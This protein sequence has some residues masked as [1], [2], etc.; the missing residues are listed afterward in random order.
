MRILGIDDNKDINE[1]LKT[2]LIPAG[3]E[4]Q[5]VTNGREGLK[6]IQEQQ[7]DVVLLDIAMPEFSGYDVVFELIKN[8]TIEK[9]PVI[10]FTAS[11]ISSDDQNHMLQLGVYC[12]LKKPI[13]IKNLLEILE[14]TKNRQERR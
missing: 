9:Q 11:T 4:Y 7:W 12:C 10:L 5:S 6:L 2:V 3:H 8:R 13:N 1:M 14:N